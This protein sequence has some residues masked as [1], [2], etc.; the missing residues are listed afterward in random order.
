[1]QLANL[2]DMRGTG[3]AEVLIYFKAPVKKQV[4]WNCKFRG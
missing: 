3:A 2:P 1:L 4:R